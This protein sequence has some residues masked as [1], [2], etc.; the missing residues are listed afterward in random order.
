MTLATDH[1]P[2]LVSMRRYLNWRPEAIVRYESS[3]SILHKL[4]YLNRAR[5]PDLLEVLAHR[6][7]LLEPKRPSR[8]AFSFDD[9]GP[10]SRRRLTWMLELPEDVVMYAR[11][12]AYVPPPLPAWSRS[13]VLRF[14]R[15]CIAQGFHT[16]LFQLPSV[17][18]CPMHDVALSECCPKCK[19][20]IPYDAT[21]KT[22]STPYGCPSC[23]TS[24]WS[25]I[26][27][28]TW[29]PG[30]SVAESSAI[31]RYLCW[32]KA[33]E[34]R[35]PTALWRMAELSVGGGSS[36]ADADALGCADDLFPLAPTASIFYKD[37]DFI[38]RS[39]EAPFLPTLS[40]DQL[41]PARRWEDGEKG[42]DTL[43]TIYPELFQ[44]YRSVRRHLK[45]RYIDKHRVCRR[46]F[47]EPG[48]LIPYEVSCRWIRG[49]RS[50]R[51][52]W[53][54]DSAYRSNHFQTFRWHLEKMGR[55]YLV[56]LAE[57]LGGGDEP[58]DVARS[59]LL[60][61]GG[62]WLALMLIA[63]FHQACGNGSA[64][65]TLQE[66]KGRTLLYWQPHEVPPRV[67]WWT[68]AIV[69]RL[70]DPDAFSHQRITRALRRKLLA[71]AKMRREQAMERVTVCPGEE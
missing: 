59:V 7:F 12:N 29:R 51:E 15:V 3:W 36:S 42:V 56:A 47:N 5:Y 22:L 8:M 13:T 11:T 38:R 52:R 10:L 69:G 18:A 43:S 49:Y 65:R 4:S 24:L 41:A 45:R 25:E 58:G 39:A 35:R 40:L 71:N 31:D 17:V 20:A 14:C 64:P 44:I 27:A 67:T 50:F 66:S 1:V 30:I 26:G 61:L 37:P 48:I 23:K 46:L 63:S 53:E 9:I 16:P 62:R 60:W 68:P 19:A 55:Q 34:T 28:S 2:K 54:G 70:D 21:T 32:A 57:R 6:T 33:L